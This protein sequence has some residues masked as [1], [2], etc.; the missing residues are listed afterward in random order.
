MRR[1]DGNGAGYSPVHLRLIW[2]INRLR[3][4]V[5]VLIFQ[6]VSLVS[7]QIPRLHMGLAPHVLGTFSHGAG[8]VRRL[9]V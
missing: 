1:N 2:Q 3:H 8:F 7:S 4:C 5:P 9:F 6:F